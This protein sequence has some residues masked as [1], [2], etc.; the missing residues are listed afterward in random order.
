[1]N[2]ETE[3]T[4][5]IMASSAI[6]ELQMIID[7]SVDRNSSKFRIESEETSVLRLFL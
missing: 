4:E 1:M 7:S 6:K 3:E 5:K 2:K